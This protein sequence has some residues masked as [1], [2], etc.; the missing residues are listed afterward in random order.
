MN[1]NSFV[2]MVSF[3]MFS[4]ICSRH[5][6]KKKAAVS[7]T[8]GAVTMREVEKHAEEDIAVREP[9]PIYEEFDPIGNVLEPSPA[10][11]PPYS[12]ENS[13][14]WKDRRMPQ[15]ERA[16]VGNPYF[17]EPPKPSTLGDEYY[18]VPSP[19]AHI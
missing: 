5:C 11:M 18:I 17:I 14:T 15:T 7:G 10:M 4:C 9:E 2:L 12:A 1:A 16:Q 19:T 13:Y 8:P 3:S 6:F